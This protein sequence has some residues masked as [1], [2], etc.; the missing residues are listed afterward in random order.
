M[1]FTQKA[2]RQW[3][4][5]AGL[6]E[7][8]RVGVWDQESTEK[9]PPTG[10]LQSLLS[11][12]FS[13]WMGYD[14]GFNFLILKE[15]NPNM[16][17]QREYHQAFR[18]SHVAYEV[19]GAWHKLH[20]LTAIKFQRIILCVFLVILNSTVPGRVKYGNKI[21]DLFQRGSWHWFEA[22]VLVGCPHLYRQL[23]GV[24]CGFCKRW[25]EARNT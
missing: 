12:Y 24:E 1:F 14:K 10:A 8:S 3:I 6:F 7:K 17:G 23:A 9:K 11:T 13:V 22:A 16:S 15:I 21:G 2:Y 25:A 18:S 19:W 4:H 20:N 5:P